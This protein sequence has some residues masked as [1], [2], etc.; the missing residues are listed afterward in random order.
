MVIIHSA[1]SQNSFPFNRQE[2]TCSH[3][4][5]LCS[6]MISPRNFKRRH[7][8]NPTGP[9]LTV[10]EVRRDILTSPEEE[11]EDTPTGNVALEN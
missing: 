9:S 8:Y 10:K 5:Y 2:P 4:S 3:V 7:L 11:Y 1:F 6:D